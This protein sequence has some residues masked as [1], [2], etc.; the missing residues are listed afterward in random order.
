MRI[1]LFVSED[2]RIECEFNRRGMLFIHNDVYRYT[3]SV[4]KAI[5]RAFEKVKRDLTVAGVR[6]I[7]TL[8]QDEKTIRYNEAFGFRRTGKVDRKT[9]AELR[10][11]E[12]RK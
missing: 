11:I 12:L 4:H 8:V 10:M 9:G 2:F 6:R 3:P 5:R 1:P 7:F